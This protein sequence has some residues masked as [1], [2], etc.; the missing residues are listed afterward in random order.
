[1]TAPRFHIPKN[2]K[3][4]VV[5]YSNKMC[6]GWKDDPSTCSWLI[7]AKL[8]I[9]GENDG[10]WVTSDFICDHTCSDSESR[11]KRN[12]SSKTINDASNA[13]S[14]FVASIKPHNNL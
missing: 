8:L 3:Y 7:N 4:Q 11:R 9:R 1:M 5:C 12:Y 2:T 14:S 6:K 13:V 10:D